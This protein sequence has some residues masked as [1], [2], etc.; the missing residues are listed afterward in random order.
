VVEEVEDGVLVEHL[1]LLMVELEDLEVEE[2]GQE[3]HRVE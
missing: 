3:L 2:Q 1:P